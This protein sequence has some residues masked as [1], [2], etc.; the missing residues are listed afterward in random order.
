MICPNCGNENDDNAKF[1]D[2]CGISLV[3]N[4][5]G[6]NAVHVIR[7]RCRNCDGIMNAD[8]TGKMMV[9]PYCGSRELIVDNEKVALAKV[10]AQQEKVRAQQEAERE[11]KKK[12][13]EI[14]KSFEK[15]SFRRVLIV[16][17]ILD[18]IFAMTGFAGNSRAS[19][20][21]GIVQAVLNMTAWLIGMRIF[22]TKKKNLPRAL[23]V[24]SWLLVIPYVVFFGT[25]GSGSYRHSTHTWE[26]SSLTNLLEKPDAE[27]ISVGVCREDLFSADVS[28]LTAAQ[29]RAYI[30]SCMAK[31]FTID[32]YTSDGG[33]DAFSED[34]TKL[35]LYFYEFMGEMSVRLR[36]PLKIDDMI[37]PTS[38]LAKLLPVPSSKRGLLDR[39][40][41][42]SLCIY[43]GD[44]PLKD[45]SAYVQSCIDAG[46]DTDFN[47]DQ[48]Y[49]RGKNEAGDSLKVEYYGNNI[50]LIELY[51]HSDPDEG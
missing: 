15:S 47:R 44:T 50:M 34:G 17:V 51:K 4:K 13:E 30:E 27:N 20:F 29:Y 2:E 16:F 21:I 41:S 37:W 18:I 43:V 1:C 31:G 42:G 36:A 45:Y 35:E 32:Q 9:C 6:K 46:F 7:M 12:E 24:I 25:E 19:G 38:A 22:R 48:R 11:E 49:F 10:K 8:E 23:F 3:V 5:P 33:Y 14:A 39:E 40:N 28:E 26:D